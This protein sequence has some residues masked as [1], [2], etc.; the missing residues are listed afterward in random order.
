ML[1]IR[2]LILAMGVSLMAASAPLPEEPRST[3]Q[4]ATAAM[5]DDALFRH[6]E[7]CAVIGSQHGFTGIDCEGQGGRTAAVTTA[8]SSTPATKTLRVEP[9]ASTTSSAT[10]SRTSRHSM[11]R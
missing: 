3:I 2:I 4:I 9:A 1:R 6:C 10:P 5:L 8:T 11:Q 7:E